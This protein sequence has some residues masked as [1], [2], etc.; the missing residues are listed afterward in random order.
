MSTNGSRW[1]CSHRSTWNKNSTD[2]ALR[3]HWNFLHPVIYY[4]VTYMPIQNWKSSTFCLIIKNPPK[5]NPSIFCSIWLFVC[6]DKVKEIIAIQ[7]DR[8]YLHP[9]LT[10]HNV[11][12]N[13]NCLLIFMAIKSCNIVV[14]L[15]KYL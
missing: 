9:F 13:L 2:S 15:D 5:E 12:R 3:L 11:A 10:F 7:K 14:L 4:I 6:S 1:D 8:E